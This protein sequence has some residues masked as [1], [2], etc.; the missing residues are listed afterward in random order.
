MRERKRERE[1][2]ERVRERERKRERE[3]ERERERYFASHLL[4]SETST[5][6]C[7]ERIEHKGKTFDHDFANSFYFFSFLLS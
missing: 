2:E 5:M 4:L 7:L 6:N 3:R 1:K